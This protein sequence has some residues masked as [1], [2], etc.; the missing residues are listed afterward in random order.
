[1]KA[2]AF[3]GPTALDQGSTGSGRDGDL[4]E[5]QL[6]GVRPPLKGVDDSECCNVRALGV[7]PKALQ[8]R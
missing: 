2:V 8:P 1:V 5:E 7:R 3:R 4:R 6:G